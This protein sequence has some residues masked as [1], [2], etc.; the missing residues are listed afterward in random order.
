VEWT[1]GL[2][3]FHEE[4]ESGEYLLG[5]NPHIPNGSKLF[6]RNLLFLAFVRVLNF[7]GHFEGLNDT[8]SLSGTSIIAKG[9]IEPI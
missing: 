9:I 3:N 7:W 6:F 4:N 1:R 8:F 2:L 5:G